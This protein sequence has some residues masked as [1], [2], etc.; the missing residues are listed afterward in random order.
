MVYL[1]RFVSSCSDDTRNGLVSV[2]CSYI[3]Q[4]CVLTDPIGV[5]R[6]ERKEK[7]SHP[8]GSCRV[9]PL[10]RQHGV[11]HAEDIS[12]VHRPESRSNSLG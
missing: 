11:P 8:L 6:G 10:S 9:E 3:Y 12:G 2:F 7:A 1:D 4:S 5:N